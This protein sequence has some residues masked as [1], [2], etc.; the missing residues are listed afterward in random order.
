MTSI[1]KLIVFQF[2]HIND[3]SAVITDLYQFDLEKHLRRELVLQKSL[4]LVQ[5]MSLA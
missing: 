2:P 5:L 3:N 1:E 4:L